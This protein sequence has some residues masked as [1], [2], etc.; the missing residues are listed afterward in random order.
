MQRG[1]CPECKEVIGGESHRLVGT[2][3]PAAA[4]TNVLAQVDPRV[5]RI[6]QQHDPFELAFEWING[7]YDDE[8][9][10][11]ERMGIYFLN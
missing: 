9:V 11:K 2:S 1:Q 6:P 10:L 4:L 3:Q 7:K 8:F 5:Q